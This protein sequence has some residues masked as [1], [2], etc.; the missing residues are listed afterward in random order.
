MPNQILFTTRITNFIQH[1]LQFL[2]F[3]SAFFKLIKIVV[4]FSH[5]LSPLVV[6]LPNCCEMKLSVC[7]VNS[8]VFLLL[9]AIHR[10]LTAPPTIASSRKKSVPTRFCK[11][12]AI[13][14]ILHNL[15]KTSS[16]DDLSGSCNAMGI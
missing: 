15:K 4:K 2:S 16:C 14:R 1:Q 11:S 8:T 13:P 10:M 6:S 9:L 12:K 3:F 7:S 5:F